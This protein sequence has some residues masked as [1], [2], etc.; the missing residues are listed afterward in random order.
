MLPF[1]PN[2][3]S[4]VSQILAQSGCS[5]STV[6]HLESRFSFMYKWKESNWCAWSSMSRFGAA[7]V[8]TFLRTQ[9]PDDLLLVA[10]S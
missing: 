5:C 7:V 6:H 4:A 8:L 10:L 2:F 1:G 3:H 9:A